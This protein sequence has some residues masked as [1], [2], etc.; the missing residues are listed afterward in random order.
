MYNYNRQS[1]TKP[2]TFNELLLAKGRLPQGGIL[3]KQ[4]AECSRGLTCPPF[5]SPTFSAFWGASPATWLLFVCEHE[6]PHPAALI[7]WE[8][9]W[10]L[11]RCYL[12]FCEVQLK[13]CSIWAE[14]TRR[15][16]C[17]F[18]S[19]PFYFFQYVCLS[20]MQFLPSSLHRHTDYKPQL[21]YVWLSCGSVKC[22]AGT[23]P[24]TPYLCS[25]LIAFFPPHSSLVKCRKNRY[26]LINSKVVKI[27]SSSK[28]CESSEDMM[29]TVPA[30]M[31]QKGWAFR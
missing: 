9:P 10:C 15:L 11:L 26:P 29:N 1:K 23:H 28:G 5:Y 21:L 17:I 16:F 19:I 22:P 7:C 27:L 2:F 8:W 12:Q 25:S 30:S 13:A 31:K 14:R 20:T 3:M 6:Q 18:Y 4:M 24:V